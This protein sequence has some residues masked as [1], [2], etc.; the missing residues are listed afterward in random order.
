MH[1]DISSKLIAKQ[2]GNHI[3]G[4]PGGSNTH[5]FDQKETPNI[6]NIQTTSQFV[7]FDNAN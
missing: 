6:G 2:G 7:P 3:H 1:D 5:I 4:H